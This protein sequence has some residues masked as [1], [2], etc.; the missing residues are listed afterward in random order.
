[1]LNNCPGADRLRG[2]PT[3][4]EHICPQCGEIIEIF[5]TDTH[6]ACDCGFVAYNDSQNCIQWCKYARDCVGDEIYN[7]FVN[8]EVNLR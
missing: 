6:V 8:R 4:K 2:T 7:K 5:S 1:M 3:I